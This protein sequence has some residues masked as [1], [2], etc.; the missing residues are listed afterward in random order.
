MEIR[1]H[2][3]WELFAQLGLPHSPEDIRS[4]IESNAPLPAG[5][6]LAQAEFWTESQAAFLQE[7]YDLDS[8]WI[9]LVDQLNEKLSH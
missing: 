8:D 1:T 3:F 2:R 9:S 7:S 6:T 5:L 4:F